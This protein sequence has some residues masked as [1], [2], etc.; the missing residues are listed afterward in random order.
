MEHVPYEFFPHKCWILGSFM[1]SKVGNHHLLLLFRSLHGYPLQPL[2]PFHLLEFR[3]TSKNKMATPLFQQEILWC[4]LMVISQEG[5]K[6]G[7]LS[8]AMLI[9][10][11]TN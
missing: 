7:A 4:Y 6:E 10:L 1:L 3:L 5:T 9:L 2:W 11:S 8:S